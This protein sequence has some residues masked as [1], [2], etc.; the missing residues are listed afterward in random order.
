MLQAMPPAPA[1][2]VMTAL[3]NA[4][5]EN[6][7]GIALVLDDYQFI[8]AP[9]VHATVRFLVEH[10]PASLVIFIA[11]RTDPPFPLARLRAQDRVAEIRAEDL[12]FVRT[13]ETNI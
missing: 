8:Q 13:A 3:I 9:E 1:E 12:R 11:T 2:L 4:I 5:Q 10:R 6:R 7:R